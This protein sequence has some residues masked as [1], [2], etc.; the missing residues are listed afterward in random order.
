MTERTCSI[1]GCERP[2][3][4]PGTARGWCSRHY[5]RWQRWGD[6]LYIPP[7]LNKGQECKVDGCPKPCKSGGLCSAHDTR[8]RRHGSLEHPEAWA[9]A[10][11]GKKWCPQCQE[12]KALGEFSPHRSTKSGLAAWCKRC[13]A[14]R[15][16][17]WRREHPEANAQ[18]VRESNR[19]KY[20]AHPEYYAAAAQ[21]RRA[22]KRGVEAERFT[23]A[24]IAERD[25]WRC[26]I[27]GKRIGR[28]IK[29]PNP[30][31]LS[32]DHIVPLSAGG[33]H[34]KVN[35][36]AAHLICNQRKYVGGA[37]LRLLG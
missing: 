31:S 9:R 19:R 10:P 32:L 12:Y 37:Q 25:G 24:E 5:G 15:Q 13:V 23:S 14:D 29:W 21:L 2:T 33:D 1:D 27:C 20:K 11:E 16:A 35:V 8:L 30:R 4:V 3:G 36:Q 17:R 18:R 6:P 22:R 26:G 7:T 34:T 28:T